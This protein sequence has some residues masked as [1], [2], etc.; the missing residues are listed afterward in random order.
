MF[1]ADSEWNRDISG[2]P[3]DPHSADYLQAMSASSLQIH[4][5]FGQPPY[6]MPVNVVSGTQPRVPMTFLYPSESDPGPYPFPQ[7]IVIQSNDDRHAAVVDKDNCRLYET[8]ATYS[9]GQGGFRADSGAMFDLTSSALRPDGWTSATASGL[10]MV[11]GLVRYDEATAGEIRHALIFT[12]SATAHAYVHPATHSSGTSDAPYAPPMG[13]RVRLRADFDVSQ[14]HGASKA[15]LIAM[16]RYGMFVVDN[17]TPMF[18]AVA[19]QQDPR[20][21]MTDLDQ[22][23]TVPASAFEVVKLGTLHQGQ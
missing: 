21:D 10:P 19:G 14:F 1:G 20:W 22:L 5:D 13:L 8:Y 23:K 9:D 7:D 15:V 6:G 18:W 11:P 12:A 16:Q 2:D 3:V 4:P 17:A